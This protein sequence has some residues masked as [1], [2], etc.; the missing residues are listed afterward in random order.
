[1]KIISDLLGTRLG[2]FR[3]GNL[4]TLSSSAITSV[5]T[6]LFPN[7]SGT[8]AL[9]EDIENIQSQLNPIGTIREFNVPTNPATLLGFGTWESYGT[10]RVTVAIDTSQAEFDVVSE[11]GGSKNHTHTFSGTTGTP[12]SNASVTSGVT[13]YAATNTHNHTFSG[14]TGSSS[15]LMP[16]IVVYRWVRTA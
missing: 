16:Y 9:L 11:V 14:T 6:I 2:L 3:I 12:T 13:F 7:K 5:Q 8:I 1:M 4:L 15:N 10:G